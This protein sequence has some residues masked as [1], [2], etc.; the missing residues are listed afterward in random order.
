ML[1]KFINILT[2]TNAIS[3]IPK[4]PFSDILSDREKA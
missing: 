3:K 4:R 1:K 2:R